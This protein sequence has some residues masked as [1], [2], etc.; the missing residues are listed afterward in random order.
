MNIAL[1][2]LF[3][4]ALFGGVLLFLE[5]GRWIGRRGNVPEETPSLGALEGAVF[6]L[7]GLLVAFTF[8]GVDELLTVDFS[9]GSPIPAGNI[10]LNTAAA[11]NPGLAVYGQSSDQQVSL[12]DTQLGPAGGPVL[13]WQNLGHLDLHNITANYYGTGANLPLTTIDDGAVLYWYGPQT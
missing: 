9:N 1:V 4:V 3:V 6:G 10:T 13:A 11:T 5:I 12:L 2:V 7:M 8:S